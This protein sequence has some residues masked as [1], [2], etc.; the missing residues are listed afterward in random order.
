MEAKQ[1]NLTIKHAS[2]DHQVGVEANSSVADLK[3]VLAEKFGIATT[4]Q[5]LIS[6]GIFR[7]DFFFSRF[8]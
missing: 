5:K 2:V 6:K 3:K 4:E 8:S 1:L 7:F